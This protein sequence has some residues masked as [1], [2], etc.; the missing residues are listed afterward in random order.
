[1]VVFYMSIT[2]I[3]ELT[4]LGSTMTATYGLNSI[5]PICMTALVTTVYTGIFFFFCFFF[6]FFFF[7]FFIYYY[8]IYI[9]KTNEQ[10]YYCNNKY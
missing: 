2:Y 1:M 7:F 8:L 4:A 3:S 9:I 10:Y 6:F 5:I